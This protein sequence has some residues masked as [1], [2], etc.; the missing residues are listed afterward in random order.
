MKAKQQIRKPEHWQDFENLCKKLWCEIWKC[1][2]IKKN[3]R[4]GQNQHGVDIYGIPFDESEYYGIQCKGKDEYTHA[5]L[6]EKEIDNEIGK[7][8]LFEPFLKKLYFATT[9]NKD[10]VIEAYIRKKNIEH[11]KNGLFEVHLFSWEDLVDLIEENRHTYDFYVKSL[12]YKIEHDIKF[13]F[14]NNKKDLIIEVPFQ[15][16]IT[17]YKIIPTLEEFKS[18]SN[19]LFNGLENIRTKPFSM[20]SFNNSYCRFFFR[21][22]NIGLEPLSEYKIFLDFKGDFESIETCTKGHYLITKQ[23]IA[24]D[25][26]IWNESKQG[27]IV[28]FKNILVP[29]DAIA[30]DTIC[31]KPHTKETEIIIHWNLISLDYKCE[32]DLNLHIKP[33]YKEIEETEFVDDFARVRIEE[34]IS[35]YI[36][37]SSN[38]K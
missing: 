16:T 3:G 18:S 11:R 14:E 5:Q 15:K 22:H 4:Q 8:R 27:K 38:K 9:A 37:D 10:S 17:N 33:F 24:Y 29:D 12:N 23:T 35:D 36:T 30:F 28:P 25:T 19:N 31:I 34:K 21:L 2:E 13:V 6:T 7:A 32:G 20:F 1:P 26:Y